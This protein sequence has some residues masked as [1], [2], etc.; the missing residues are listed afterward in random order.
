M[1]HRVKFCYT[2][3]TEIRCFDTHFIQF[4]VSI[5]SVM[6]SSELYVFKICVFILSM[7]FNEGSAK[8]YCLYF[9][10]NILFPFYKNVL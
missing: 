3:S 6:K 1:F 5:E 4:L 8:T 7:L 9:D 10:V 2:E